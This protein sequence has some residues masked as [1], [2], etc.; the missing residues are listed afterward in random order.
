MKKPHKI[1]DCGDCLVVVLQREGTCVKHGLSVERGSGHA[2]I[3]TEAYEKYWSV[4]DEK[5][6]VYSDQ[7]PNPIMTYSRGGNTMAP[8]P[9]TDS[10]SAFDETEV[11]PTTDSHSAFNPEDE[12]RDWTVVQCLTTNHYL[13]AELTV[14]VT[15]GGV[16]RVDS[17]VKNVINYSG[18]Y[19]QIYYRTAESVSSIVT[20]DKRARFPLGTDFNG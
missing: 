14:T 7:G 4:D 12:V 15:D 5:F 17:P 2:K 10:H 16:L 20:A 13:P 19:W 9:T 3:T 1:T 8:D 6:E 11:D 18:S